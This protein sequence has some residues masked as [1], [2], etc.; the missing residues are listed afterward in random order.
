MFIYGSIWKNNHFHKKK[1]LRN[2]QMIRLKT[3]NTNNRTESMCLKTESNLT[4]GTLKANRINQRVR[5]KMRYFP[6]IVV[7]HLR[8]FLR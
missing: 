3:L 5:D 8:C 2:N 7:D 6:L 1:T 4:K